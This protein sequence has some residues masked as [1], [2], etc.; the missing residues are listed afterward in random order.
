MSVLPLIQF[1]HFFYRSSFGGKHRSL[2]RPVNSLQYLRS[3]KNESEIR[4]L[5]VGGFRIGSDGIIYAKGKKSDSAK[6]S[7][8]RRLIR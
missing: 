1:Q 3:T 6:L 7:W 4:R 8:G 5:L 2:V